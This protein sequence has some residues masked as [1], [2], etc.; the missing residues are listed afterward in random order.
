MRAKTEENPTC[1]LLWCQFLSRRTP[2]EGVLYILAA[3]TDG[4]LLCYRIYKGLD[5]LHIWELA[6]TSHINGY[7]VLIKGK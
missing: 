6:Y 2:A 3:G 4:Q 5:I 7:F 1:D